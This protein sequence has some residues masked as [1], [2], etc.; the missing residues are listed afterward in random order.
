MKVRIVKFIQCE[1]CSINGPNF[2]E[3]S[4]FEAFYITIKHL[5]FVTFIHLCTL[6]L[7]VFV[8]RI[9][10]QK[11]KFKHYLWI[12]EFFFSRDK[13]LNCFSRFGKN[14][15]TYSNLTCYAYNSTLIMY[16]S[17]K[18]IKLSIWICYLVTTSLCE[19]VPLNIKRNGP[20]WYPSCALT[21]VC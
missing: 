12:F 16:L 15:K 1:P 17:M 14:C 19:G 5:V 6:I 18:K 7:K 11:N 21:L 3:I 20:F 2:L 4:F 8:V 9:L 13:V 10:G